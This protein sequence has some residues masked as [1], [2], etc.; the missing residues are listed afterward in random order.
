MLIVPATP[1]SAPDGTQVTECDQG[2]IEG[3]NNVHDMA[4]ITASEQLNMMH[5]A[6]A[7]MSVVSGTDGGSSVMQNIRVEQLCDILSK[8]ISRVREESV[9]QAQ[10]MRMQYENE[11]Q[12][13]RQEFFAK[14]AANI[15]NR[16]SSG[17]K[18]THEFRKSDCFVPFNDYGINRKEEIG[19]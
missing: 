10:E 9:Q 17:F 8:E 16:P 18:S 11:L 3:L 6:G 19:D 5:K 1:A 2:D 15:P 4:T 12:A 7:P 13:L 14:Q